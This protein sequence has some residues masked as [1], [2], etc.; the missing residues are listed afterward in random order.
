[1]S[2]FSEMKTAGT[3]CVRRAVPSEVSGGHQG[4]GQAVDLCLE[5]R[6]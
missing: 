6:G 3:L 5:E 1:M 4:V 2:R